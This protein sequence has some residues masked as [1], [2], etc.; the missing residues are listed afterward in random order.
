M[1]AAALAHRG[2]V[3]ALEIVGGEIGD[4]RGWKLAAFVAVG[5][6]G[7]RVGDE[8]VDRERRSG[9]RAGASRKQ[10]DK[11]EGQ[12]HARIIRAIA[13]RRIS[14]FRTLFGA[15]LVEG[16]NSGVK[17]QHCRGVT[18]GIVADAF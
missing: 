5:D 1:C 11:Y 17:G 13:P 8:C 15:R 6:V 14:L 10:R 2:V 18:G 7:G 12:F 4:Q 9:R 16:F 3:L